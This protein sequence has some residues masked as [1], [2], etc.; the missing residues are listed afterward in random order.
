MAN[1]PKRKSFAGSLWDAAKFIGSS[2]W[3]NFDSIAGGISTI[4]PMLLMEPQEPDED[5][6][7]KLLPKVDY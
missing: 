7:R 5:L 6:D 3:N 2:V 4:A 1:H